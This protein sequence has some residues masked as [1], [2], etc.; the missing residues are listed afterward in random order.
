M[1]YVRRCLMLAM[2]ALLAAGC[3]K[4]EEAAS[5]KRSLDKRQAEEKR[6]KMREAKQRA[7]KQQKISHKA[8]ADILR[9]RGRGASSGD[10]K[11]VRDQL[12][13]SPQ[14][15]RLHHAHG[16]CLRGAGKHAEALA[17]LRKAAGLASY[18]NDLRDDLA[19]ACFKASDAKCW[20]SAY[21]KLSRYRQL[22][23]ASEA[24]SPAIVMF[25]PLGPRAEAES[26]QDALVRKGILEAR[27]G[28]TGAALEA[29]K[30]SL[31]RGVNHLP[32]LVNLALVHSMERNHR[33]G[34]DYLNR[35]LKI[36]EKE[37]KAG[38]P[39]PT[40]LALRLARAVLHHRSARHSLALEEY[41]ILLQL[42]PDHTQGL[43]GLGAMQSLLGKK[44][45]ALDTYNRLQK[46]GATALA[47]TL[48]R[49]IMRDG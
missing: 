44:N 5:N 24:S 16:L 6:R 38:T 1:G 23:V 42:K 12:A 41:K 43:Y 28:R 45:E 8:A 26:P 21:G 48:F 4:K 25:E 32:T 9:L 10:C 2:V 40:L 37:K 15:A 29:L 13:R 30:A 34:M 19:L 35:A 49:I 18:G 36:L 20:S 27:A 22:R 31:A 47:N 17:S 11:I 33:G 7:H 3:P 14:R 39:T 46:A